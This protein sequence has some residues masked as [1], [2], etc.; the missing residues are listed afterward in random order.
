M[1]TTIMQHTGSVSFIMVLVTDG[2]RMAGSLSGKKIGILWTGITEKTSP[3]AV[4]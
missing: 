4:S 3:E 1:D 2:T